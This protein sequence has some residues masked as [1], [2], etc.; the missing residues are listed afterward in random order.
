[1]RDMHTNTQISLSAD[2]LQISHSHKV[3][4]LFLWHQKKHGFRPAESQHERALH[5]Q[6]FQRVCILLLTR[7]SFEENCGE[8]NKLKQF[9][10]SISI[11]LLN[12]LNL[13]ARIPN[14]F[15]TTL[16]ALDNLQLKILLDKSNCLEG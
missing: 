8:H 4:L 6:M 12:T 10:G 11:V 5:H 3:H 9:S 7:F 15:S 2:M 13:L 16:L 14:T 1:M